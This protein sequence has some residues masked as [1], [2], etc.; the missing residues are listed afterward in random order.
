MFLFHI[1]VRSLISKSEHCVSIC[2]MTTQSRDSEVFDMAADVL[3]QRW[4]TQLMF[5]QRVRAAQRQ[6]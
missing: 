6:S 2:P 1:Y 5:S 3:A 4:T